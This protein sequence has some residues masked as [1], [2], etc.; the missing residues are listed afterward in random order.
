MFLDLPTFAADFEPSSLA[1][2][3]S[4]RKHCSTLSSERFW[5]VVWRLSAVHDR[6][7]D[8][9]LDLHGVTRTGSRSLFLS[10]PFSPLPLFSLG[11]RRC[12]IVARLS[13]YRA[14]GTVNNLLQRFDNKFKMSVQCHVL[15][16]LP[17]FRTRCFLR[18]DSSS[19]SPS[20][21]F[22]AH[23]SHVRLWRNIDNDY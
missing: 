22:H 21:F 2:L 10:P 1:S 18:I 8:R 19:R 12:V 16:D 17:I 5:Y 6:S 7:C 11:G 13:L 23:I 3:P 9:S 15:L 20:Q 14:H 4:F